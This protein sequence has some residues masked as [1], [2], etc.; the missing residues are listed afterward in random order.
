MKKILGLTEG[1]G[2]E[3]SL[4]G[5]RDGRDQ[6]SERRPHSGLADAVGRADARVSCA[7]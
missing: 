1:R 5:A 2:A 6:G 4:C 3:I 7:V